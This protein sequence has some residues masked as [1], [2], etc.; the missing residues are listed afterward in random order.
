MDEGF[1][2]PEPTA[3]WE[4]SGYWE[5]AARGELV[6]QR[7]RDCGLVQHRPRGICAHC[8]SSS[9][10]HFVASGRGTVHTFTV[11]HQNQMRAFRGACPYVLAYVDLEEG[12]RLMTNIVDC[13]PATVRIGQAVVPDFSPCK[14][15]LAVPRFRPA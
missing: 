7:C 11:I 13:D 2:H 9:I 15:G 1:E 12:P 6:L 8:L 4:T 10:D 14:N 5:G 3:D